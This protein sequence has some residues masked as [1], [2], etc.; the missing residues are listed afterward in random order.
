MVSD[1]S[2]TS[3]R[4]QPSEEKK[5]DPTGTWTWST[6][7][8]NGSPD[9]KSTL[10]LKLE[11]DKVTG[12]LSAP[13]RDGQIIV[14]AVSQGKL[15]GDEISFEVSREFQG[16]KFTAKYN[17]KISGDSIKGK[18]ET[19][20]NGQTQSRNW[21]AKRVSSY[22]VQRAQL[23]TAA[24]YSI[25]GM[26]EP[27][28][29]K[30]DQDAWRY[31]QKSF[32]QPHTSTRVARTQIRVN[33]PNTG[34]GHWIEVVLDDGNLIKL[35]DGSLWQVSPLDVIDSALWLPISDITIIEGNDPSYPYKLVNTDDN[36]IVNARLIKE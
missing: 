11:G 35:E 24:P 15:K 21:E 26:Q 23:E 12:T 6:L 32:S 31:S 4:T 19:E 27:W 1:V 3:S 22:E 7:G 16:N 2:P 20:R 17:G 29:L 13:G 18:L 28:S 9:R 36:E 8:R 10:K 34:S 25:A 33:S 14:V 5:T 30:A